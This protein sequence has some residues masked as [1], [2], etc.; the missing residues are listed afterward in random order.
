[1]DYDT[2]NRKENIIPIPEL[3][4]EIIDAINHENLV[5]F[6]GAGVSRIMGCKGWSELANDL[7]NKCF[8]MNF[9]NYK[10]KIFLRDK[11]SP[12][13]SISI[14]RHIFKKHNEEAQFI[15]VI[16]KSLESNEKKANN[17]P[18][19]EYMRKIGAVY[20]TTN[21]DTC[22]DE[23]YFKDSI[24]YDPED[25]NIEKLD[26]TRLFHLHGTIKAPESMIFTTSE[27]LRHYNDDNVTNFLKALFAPPNKILFIGYGMEEYEILDYLFTKSSNSGKH[28]ILLP[29][30][31]NDENVLEFEKAYYNEMGIEVIPYAID[32]K[33]Y[34]QLYYII[35]NW[36]KNALLSSNFLDSNF[37]YLEENINNFNDEVRRKTFELIRSHNSLEDYFFNIVS[38]LK[39]FN[40]LYKGGYFDADKNPAPVLKEDGYE[41][42][43]WNVLSYLVK[44]SER[45]KDGFDDT[46]AKMIMQIVRWVSDYRHDGKKIDNYY[47]YQSFVKIMSILVPYTKSEDIKLINDY[48][49]SKWNS[50][51][52]ES[53]IVKELVPSL[54]E[55]DEKSK[56]NELLKIIISVN[57]TD[58]YDFT[59]L[60]EV[61]WVNQVFKNYGEKISSLIPLET[62]KN[63]INQIEE[64]RN[65]SPN[66]F[67]IVQIP[68]IENHPRESYDTTLQDILVYISRDMLNSAVKKDELSTNEF[69]E[70]ILGPYNSISKRICFLVI[71][72]NWDECKDIFCR[73][74]GKYMFSDYNLRNEVYNILERHFN[75][76]TDNKKNEILA[77]IDNGPYNSY[78]I[79]NEEDKCIWKQNWLLTLIKSGYEPAI[80]LYESC[81][82]ITHR[83]AEGYEP[84]FGD[85]KPIW[86]VPKSNE[87]SNILKMSNKE[88]SGYLRQFNS[89][90]KNYFSTRGIEDDLHDN[91]RG[92][93]SK[94][95]NDL[96]CFVEIPFNYQAMIISG[97]SDA[98]AQKQDLEWDKI[99]DYCKEIIEKC[100]T[101]VKDIKRD[102]DILNDNKSVIVSIADLIIKGTEDDSNTFDSKYLPVSEGIL[103][104]INGNI[105]SELEYSENLL[106]RALNTVK[107]RVLHALISNSLR[108]EK[109][110]KESNK[111]E[112]MFT[113]M[114]DRKIEPN[115]E[116]SVLLGFFLPRISI[117]NKKWVEENIQEIFSDNEDHWKA[118]MEGYLADRNVYELLYKLLNKIGFYKKAI[119]MNF[120]NKDALTKLV[121][122]VCM[123]YL[124][125]ND[126]N[127]LNEYIRLWKEDDIIEIIT[128][129]WIKKEKIRNN[130]WEEKIFDFWR[131]IHDNLYEKTNLTE[132]DKLI[133]L[134]INKLSCFMDNIN[135]EKLSWLNFSV[136]FIGKSTYSFL[137]DDLNRLVETNSREVGIIYLKIME[138]EYMPEF[139]Q[140]EI[141]N[142][143]TTLYN[144]DQR[145]I[146]D[147]ISNM[148]LKNGY[149]FHRDIYKKYNSSY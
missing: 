15:K 90:N 47:T 50:V 10:E 39:W 94:Y 40:S 91:V 24:I 128:F 68:S 124:R 49:D 52:V 61:H 102:N 105:T 32:E 64:I 114:L 29:M 2:K 41:I 108:F 81:K 21:V 110:V 123:G 16:S 63:A 88:I 57:W 144:K 27:Y 145:N 6:I 87:F 133:L 101:G 132:K 3:K 111:I 141:R 66:E 139:E 122:H 84:S 37:V 106:L 53:S 121:S 71:D 5:L 72:L 95:Y 55:S 131:A 22:F 130:G 75:Y 109:A 86:G 14:C 118:T 136:G 83:D 30:Y 65:K 98:W 104:K 13:E 96:N 78:D 99:F 31:Q 26:G 149:E 138:N 33:G 9:I 23:L 54:I 146:A 73:N 116:W 36:Q 135:A 127:L 59:P 113:P 92:N 82:E 103:A 93:P 62:A 67:N 44:V 140:N 148:Y 11:K 85:M 76:L 20:V 74:I 137:I 18:I 17:F 34:E 28:F 143:L 70:K 43:R 48:L 79:K 1:M 38:D 58:K 129:F 60:M 119:P 126:E 25:F 46:I 8:E 69:L 77:L 51:L 120:S 142:I 125:E 117:L 134:N 80:K 115:L 147:K 89:Q 4:K 42:P 7:I 35:K 19:Y 45:V 107:G 97:F 112:K 12:K 100:F 56:L